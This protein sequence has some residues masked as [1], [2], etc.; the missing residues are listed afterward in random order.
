MVNVAKMLVDYLKTRESITDLIG[1]QHTTTVLCGAGGVD[2]VN[3]EGAYFLISDGLDTYYVWTDVADGSDDPGAEGGAL[4][5]LG[6]TGIEVDIAVD[7]IVGNIALAIETAVEAATDIEVTVDIA[8]CTLVASTRGYSIP[9][10]DEG[11]AVPF[12]VTNVHYGGAQVYWPQAPAQIVSL[13]L[14]VTL[15]DGNRYHNLNYAAPALQI[16]AFGKNAAKVEQ[17]KEAV[18]TELRDGRH[19]IDGVFV[20][21]VYG[22]DRMSEDGEWWHSPIEVDLRLQEAS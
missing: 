18:I 16:S 2:N 6:Y 7:T 14:V 21:S 13:H 20:V 15:I 4:E 17:L 22:S 11:D 3:Y 5:G 19:L 8:N 1:T 9:S 12:T 10:E